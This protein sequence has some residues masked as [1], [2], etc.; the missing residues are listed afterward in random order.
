MELT[1][2]GGLVDIYQTN[3]NKKTVDSNIYHIEIKTEQYR[4]VSDNLSGDV[5]FS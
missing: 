5:C 3:K 1:C 2:V 4:I